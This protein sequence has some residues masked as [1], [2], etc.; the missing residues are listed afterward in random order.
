MISRRILKEGKDVGKLHGGVYTTFVAL[1]TRR[2]SSDTEDITY[3]LTRNIY[4]G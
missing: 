3:P 2:V 1:L 4:N